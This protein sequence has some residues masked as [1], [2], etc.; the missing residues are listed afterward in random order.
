MEKQQIVSW[1]VSLAGHQFDLEA[2]PIWLSGRD[3]HVIQRDATFFLAIP[4]RIVGYDCE[5]VGAFA[6]RQLDL[7]NGVG[8]LLSSTFRAISLGGVIYGIDLSGVIRHTVVGLSG[9]EIRAGAGSLHA[10]TEG[11]VQPNPQIAAA[12][13]LIRA[14]EF[15]RQA[16]DALTIIG[17]PNLTWAELF[18]LFELVENDVGGQM[19]ARG[20]IASPDAKLFSRT[21]NSYSA[22][23]S[24]GRH[25]KDK[26]LPPDCP[27][28]HGEAARQIRNLVLAW[29]LHLGA[30]NLHDNI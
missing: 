16:K 29:L 26:G 2:L 3:L 21:A 28:P 20:W 25:G 19:H 13:P 5:P 24:E 14:A 12:L 11:A 7:I 22:L 6:E 10:V 17:R 4:S 23:G 30:N 18:V 9:V 27:M 15:S 1:I 8:H